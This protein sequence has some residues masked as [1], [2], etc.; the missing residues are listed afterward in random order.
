MKGDRPRDLQD[1]C[2]STG[3]RRE[4]TAELEYILERWV[5]SINQSAAAAGEGCCAAP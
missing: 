5:D 3:S 1:S 2:D 4:S